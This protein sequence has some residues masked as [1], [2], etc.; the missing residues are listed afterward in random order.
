MIDPRWEEAVA[1]AVSLLLLLP[2][3]A[4]ALT[5]LCMQKKPVA[6]CLSLWG[7]SMK[8]WMGQLEG[9]G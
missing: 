4:C 9:R 8:G 1:A 3:W 6:D 2:P 7:G 5:P